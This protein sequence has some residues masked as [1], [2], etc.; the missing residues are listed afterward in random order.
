[1]DTHDSDLLAQLAQAIPVTSRPMFGCVG[2]YSE[3]AFFA[4]IDHGRLYF[5]TNPATRPRYEGMSQFDAHGRTSKSYYEV[6]DHV[7][8]ESDALREWSA[9]AVTV[10]RKR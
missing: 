10:A 8:D 5:K 3:G 2:V 1:M 7:I 6:P 9:E 4:I